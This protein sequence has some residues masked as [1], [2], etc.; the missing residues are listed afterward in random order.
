MLWTSILVLAA[1]A[2]M[3]WDHPRAP[4]LNWYCFPSSPGIIMCGLD[5]KIAVIKGRLEGRR[6]ELGIER[7]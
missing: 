3:G 2:R 5:I 6:G 7:S 4:R 1:G